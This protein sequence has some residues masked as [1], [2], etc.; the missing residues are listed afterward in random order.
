MKLSKN[1]ILGKLRENYPV[2]SSKYGIK[3]IGIF[4]SYAKDMQ[5]EKSDVDIIVEFEKPIGLKFMEFSYY[6]ENLMESKTDILTFAGLEAIR[7]KKISQEIKE[8]IIYV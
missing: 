7:N 1:I 3:Q 4:G 8:T 6:L 5:N 2:L